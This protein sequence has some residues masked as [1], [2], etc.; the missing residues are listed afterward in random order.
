MGTL[1]SLAAAVCG[2]TPLMGLLLPENRYANYVFELEDVDVTDWKSA[3]PLPR[4]LH[5]R[6]SPRI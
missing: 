2:R 4:L 1:I 3:L 5:R 6:S